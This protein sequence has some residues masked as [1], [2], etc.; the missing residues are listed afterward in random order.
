M[1]SFDRNYI[2]LYGN[3]GTGKTTLIRRVL[4]IFDTSF[5]ANSPSFTTVN[6]HKNNFNTFHHIDTYKM[7]KIPAS[8][9]E[10]YL[11][12]ADYYFIE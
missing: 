4:N 8:F 2:L 10:E 5:K 11:N 6:V 3:L 12:N 7:L 1:L 9:E